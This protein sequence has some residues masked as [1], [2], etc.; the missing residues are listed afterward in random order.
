MRGE[1]GERKALLLSPLITPHCGA[2]RHGHPGSVSGG[3]IDP[4][5]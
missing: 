5:L 2:A 4:R 1:G 3:G